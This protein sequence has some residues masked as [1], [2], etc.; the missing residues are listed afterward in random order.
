[1]TKPA[2]IPPNVEVIASVRSGY[3][4]MRDNFEYLLKSALIP[5]IVG[6]LNYMAVS[7][8]WEDE[9]IFENFL[10]TLPTTIFFAWYAFIQIRLQVFDEKHTN[11][12]A[13]L[14][15]DYD[16]RQ[17][18]LV[19]C[20]SLYILFQMFLTVISYVIMLVSTEAADQ[21]TLE[22]YQVFEFVFL[23]ATVLWALKFSVLHIVVS[24]EAG[25][26]DFLKRVRGIW[27]SY[28]IL[29]I[30]F[31]SLMPLI[32]L[33]M[34]MLGLI[35]PDPEGAERTATFVIYAV[36]T[37]MTWMMITVLNASIVPALKQLYSKKGLPKK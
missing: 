15:K 32:L 9:S 36:G 17:K 3:A 21:E 19:A 5:M 13:L 6:F 10:A 2:N 8:F 31:M 30:G 33:F 23:A 25:I 7:F 24:V 22:T 34:F 35:L 11:L 37:V 26:K 12:S 28:T 20:I 16:N 27:F 4:F 29:A 14:P 18:A 1:M